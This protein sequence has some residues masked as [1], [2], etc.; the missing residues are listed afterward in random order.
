MCVDVAQALPGQPTR[1]HARLCFV[2]ESASEK[3]CP[4][5]GDTSSGNSAYCAG[6]GAELAAFATL[7]PGD[8][9]TSPEMGAVLGAYQLIQQLAVGGMGRVFLAEHMR[10]GRK[11]A[12][13][14][15]R[16]EYSQN[17]EAVTRFFAEARAVNR[18]AHEN[19]VEITD[20]VENDD[21]DNY[22]IMELLEGDDLSHIREQEGVIPLARSLGVMVQVCDALAAVHDAGIIHRDLKPEN[23][24]LTSR[25][26]QADFVK[27]LDFGVA[28]L[29]EPDSGTN[30]SVQTTGVGA[31]LGTPQYM[32]PEQASAKAIDY[33]SDVYSLGII[34]Y[35]LVTGDL[36]FDAD[37]FGELLVKHLTTTPTRPTRIKG[38]PYKVP[39]E[40]ER[41]IMRCLEKEPTKRPQSMTEIENSL[42]EI[43]DDLACALESYSKPPPAHRISR[44]LVGAAAA[45]SAVL[46]VGGWVL[47]GAAGG[48][49][50]KAATPTRATPP[51]ASV[52]ASGEVSIRFEST[53]PGAEVFREGTDVS[54][55]VTP[56]TVSLK[57]SATVGVFELRKAGHTNT[58]ES[59]ALAQN[60][61]VMA[62][63]EAKA[64]KQR[65]RKKAS[66]KT[67][68]TRKKKVDR[69]ELD[70][71]KVIPVFG[72]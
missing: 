14:M 18:I 48:S 23:I 36:P 42:R 55:G 13:K 45:A 52:V 64:A 25:G 65:P 29:V 12:I 71:N 41:L 69:S 1:V 37:S 53:P 21:G 33:R 28:K 58:V 2:V 38:L 59:V 62:T 6:C 30:M 56:V 67:R 57:R 31:I 4:S 22:Y 5:C 70:K 3:M 16:S 46:I 39:P 47:F 17:R 61:T 49:K 43:A 34:L 24:F 51:P 19:I 66:G 15:L 54:L 50:D 40:L 72:Q 26:G 10:L 8:I 7:L 44:R 11:V 20:F 35:E 60:A 63:L 32:S 9:D 27:L 68:K